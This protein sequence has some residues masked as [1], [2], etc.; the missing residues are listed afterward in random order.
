MNI[1]ITGANGQLGHCIHDLS[2]SYDDNFFFTDISGDFEYYDK[3][4]I[5]DRLSIDDYVKEHKID[6]VINCAAYTNV[7]GAE[8]NQELCKNLNTVTP[9]YL[10][11]A[12]GNKGIFIHVSTD[13]V[14]GGLSNN[15]PLSENDKTSPLG[16][17]GSTKND[18]EQLLNILFPDNTIIVRTAWL[19]SEYGKNFVKTMMNLFSTKEELKVVYDQIGSPTYAKDLASV[20]LTITHKYDKKLSGTY[21]FTNEGVCSWYDFADEIQRNMK[22]SKTILRPCL[23]SEFP[24]PAKRPSYS[25][26]DK[27]K[28][29]NTFEI[30]IRH[31]KDALLE[32]MGKIKI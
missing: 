5:T 10:V 24:T 20:L 30:D 12:L 21:H 14:F 11:A 1:L 27:S 2:S 6:C 7:D 9:L 22:D 18:G 25:V 19:Y 29:K 17:Y 23:S 31:W 13:Y 3:L 15:I 32:C 8:S 4:D 28:I 16:V 26:L